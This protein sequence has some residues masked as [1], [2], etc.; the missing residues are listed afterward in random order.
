MWVSRLLLAYLFIGH[1][2]APTANAVQGVTI[3]IQN[4][5]YYCSSPPA[6]LLTVV[7]ARKSLI[8]RMLKGKTF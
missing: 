2:T 7:I 3:L 8:I 1:S 5:I 6:P 4:T